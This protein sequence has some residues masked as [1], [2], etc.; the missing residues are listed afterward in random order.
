MSS[1]TTWQTYRSTARMCTQSH[2]GSHIRHPL[3]P[4]LLLHSPMVSNHR[5][6]PATINLLQHHHTNNAELRTIHNNAATLV[7]MEDMAET[8]GDNTRMQ[9]ELEAMCLLKSDTIN[10]LE[11]KLR[12]DGDMER[13]E[14]LIHENS[15]PTCYTATLVD[16]TWIIMALDVPHTNR[17]NT[18]SIMQL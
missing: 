5:L 2:L 12:Q 4:W 9:E 14:N 1:S 13:R 16:L 17:R 3:S 8:Q 11:D 6:L 18:I 15:I 10:M 7:D